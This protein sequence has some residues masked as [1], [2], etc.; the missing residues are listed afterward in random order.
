MY[1]S[2]QMTSDAVNEAERARERLHDN[3]A[4]FLR[5]A[6]MIFAYENAGGAHAL[7]YR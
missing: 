2:M 3:A 6:C 7:I 5:L 1:G 4:R